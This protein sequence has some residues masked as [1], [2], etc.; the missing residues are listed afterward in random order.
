[1]INLFQLTGYDS[2]ISKLAYLASNT[3][4]K[5]SI[6]DKTSQKFQK[7]RSLLG[8]MI[9]NKRVIYGVNTGMGSILNW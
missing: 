5:S 7:S 3:K 8:K 9:V 2:S 1:M 6:S 4:I